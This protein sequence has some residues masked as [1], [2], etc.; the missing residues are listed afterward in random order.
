MGIH[1]TI[2]TFCKIVLL[3]NLK[4]HKSGLWMAVKVMMILIRIKIKRRIMIKTSFQNLMKKKKNG[5]SESLK[6]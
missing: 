6:T 2:L 3:V 1:L 4:R 5:S